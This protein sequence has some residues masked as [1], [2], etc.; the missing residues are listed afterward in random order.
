MERTLGHFASRFI[1]PPTKIG[2]TTIRHPLS[3][4][5]Q[6]GR[7]VPGIFV[8]LRPVFELVTLRIISKLLL[9]KS[10][11]GFGSLRHKGCAVD[12]FLLR[13]VEGSGVRVGVGVGNRPGT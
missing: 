8:N 2:E 4:R 10:G 13:V 3:T 7:I 5:F 9:H 1:I 12:L 6:I 11:D